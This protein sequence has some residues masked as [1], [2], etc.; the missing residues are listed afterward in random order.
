MM[1]EVQI[2]MLEGRTPEQIK[3]IVKNITEV[4]VNDAGAKRESVHIIIREFDADHY[5][6][7]G[8]LK[9]DL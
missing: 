3:A 7:G 4:M 8:T 1:P 5:A 6:V 2:D 9:R